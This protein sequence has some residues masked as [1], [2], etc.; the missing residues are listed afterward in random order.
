MLCCVCES[1][2]LMGFLGSAGGAEGR[3][4]SGVEHPEVFALRGAS[5]VLV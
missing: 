1:H 3:P 5:E 4:E 2:L